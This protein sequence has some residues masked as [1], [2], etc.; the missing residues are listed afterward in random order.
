[1]ILN[2]QKLFIN[3]EDRDLY[4]HHSLTLAHCA[5]PWKPP[6]TGLS[7]PSPHSQHLLSLAEDGV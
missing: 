5:F 6:V 3:G 2:L 4:L 1:M 7:L